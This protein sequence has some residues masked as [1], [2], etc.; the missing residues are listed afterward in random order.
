[1]GKYTK[2]I[3]EHVRPKSAEDLRSA[4]PNAPP[5]IIN[6]LIARK[7]DKG[8]TSPRIPANRLERV[9]KV[10]EKT[11]TSLPR[12]IRRSKR[13]K[14]P[15]LPVENQ[16]PCTKSTCDCRFLKHLKESTLSQQSWRFRSQSNHERKVEVWGALD[17]RRY[18]NNSSSSLRLLL[19]SY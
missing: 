8:Y 6:D 17:L 14:E 3:C 2:G 18:S 15:L 13:S 1:M 16:I 7:F 12:K 10:R 11:L 19:F 5:D 9:K 4:F